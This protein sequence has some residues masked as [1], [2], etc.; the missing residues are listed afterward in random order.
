MTKSIANNGFQGKVIII[1]GGIGGSAL[2]LFLHKAGIPCVIYEAYAY[3][4]GVGGG[5][6]LAPNGLN[7]LAALGLAEKVKAR[8]SLARDSYFYSEGGRVLARYDNTLKYGQPCI[9]LRRDKRSFRAEIAPRHFRQGGIQW[10]HH[11]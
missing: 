1:G 10:R 8:G 6:G 4:E 3:K 11:G 9:S 2:G 7:V 5:L